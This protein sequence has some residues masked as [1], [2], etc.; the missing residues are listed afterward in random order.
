MPYNPPRNFET[1]YTGFYKN[2]SGSTQIGALN[3]HS[4]ERRPKPKGET[5][6]GVPKAFAGSSSY[7]INYTNVGKLPEPNKMPQKKFVAGYGNMKGKSSYQEDFDARD[8][9]KHR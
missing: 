3:S 6:D 1:S 7:A 8:Q 2:S 9:K 4:N 5:E